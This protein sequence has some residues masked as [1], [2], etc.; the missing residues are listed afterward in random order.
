MRV[1]VPCWANHFYSSRRVDGVILF[2][3]AR[4]S[5]SEFGETVN[6]DQYS[7]VAII[8]GAE[9]LVI[10]FHQLVEVPTLD[11]L[12]MKTEGARLISFLLTSM[13][14]TDVFPYSATN[15]WPCV[16]FLDTCDNFANALVTNSILCTKEN[17]MLV[18]LGHHAIVAAM[19][20]TSH[21][22]LRWN[23]RIII[24]FFCLN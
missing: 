16:A 14:L 19:E 9:L 17:L 3:T 4:Y 24:L 12:E 20:D 8:G 21:R 7:R 22:E 18:Q 6:D 1:G 13:A 5:F 2:V 23:S 10:I 15:F 11:V